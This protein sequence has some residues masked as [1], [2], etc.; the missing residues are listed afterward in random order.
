MPGEVIVFKPVLAEGDSE[1]PPGEYQCG[2]EVTEELIEQAL[3][4]GRNGPDVTHPK[5]FE[6]YFSALFSRLDLDSKAIQGD[7]VNS[8]RNRLDFPEVSTRYRLIDQAT[9]QV[10]VRYS[11]D[12]DPEHSPITAVLDRVE[13]AGRMAAMDPR[14]LQPY[15]VNLYQ[16]EFETAKRRGLLV[17]IVPGWWDWRYGQYDNNL[18]VVFQPRSLKPV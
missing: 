4:D 18:G 8:P 15:L 3:V 13:C 10:V 7:P 14:R 9:Y 17:P 1:V 16:N 5:T 12:G 2:T 6:R 11:P